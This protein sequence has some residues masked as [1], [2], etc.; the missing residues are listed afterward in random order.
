MNESFWDAQGV[1]IEACAIFE[2]FAE[3]GRIPGIG[4]T[5]D[6]GILRFQFET[7]SQ[8]RSSKVGK[9]GMPQS[10]RHERPRSSRS[11]HSNPDGTT[12]LSSTSVAQIIAAAMI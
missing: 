6:G 9:L 3:S 10:R 1:E 5:Q 4:G 7:K 12:R 2:H 11:Q 8:L